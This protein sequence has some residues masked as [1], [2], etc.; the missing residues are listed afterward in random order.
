MQTMTDTDRAAVPEIDAQR[1]PARFQ[2]PA[3]GA[4]TSPCQTEAAEE[5]E[6][7]EVFTP[8]TES[9]ADWLLGKIADA[10]ARAARV[11]ENAEKIARAHDAEADGLEFRFGPAL[12]AFAQKELTGKRKSLRLLNGVIGYRTHPA[13][14]TITDPTDAGKWAREFCPAAIV[15]SLDRKVLAAALLETGE[16]VGFARFTPAEEVFYIK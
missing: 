12:Q 8:D 1:L 11:R 3:G 5:A 2:A 6:T 15:T 16:S 7:P 14:V 13:G 4:D 9:K 10:R